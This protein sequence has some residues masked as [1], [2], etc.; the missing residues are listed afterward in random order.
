MRAIGWEHGGSTVSLVV[1]DY[2]EETDAWRADLGQLLRLAEA[3]NRLIIVDPGYQRHG[4]LPDFVSRPLRCE[5]ERREFFISSN[6]PGE[7]V[8]GGMPA[9]FLERLCH[10]LVELTTDS[11]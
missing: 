5:F 7:V 2:P 9:T 4:I 1:E 8:V 10:G 6:G 11:A 3:Q